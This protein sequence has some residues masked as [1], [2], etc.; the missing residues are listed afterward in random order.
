MFG[1]GTILNT[2][3]V[4]VGSAFGLAMKKGM[5]QQL[6]DILMSACGL[7]VMFIGAS[8]TFAGMLTVQDGAIA[9]QGS[10]LLIASLVLGGLAGQLVDIEKRMD[11]LGEKLKKLFHAEGD[12]RFVD[13]FVSASL[14]I[15]VGAMAIVGSIQDGLNGDYSTLAVKAVLDLI[16]MVVFAASYGPGAMCSAIAIFVYQGAIT[17]AAHFIGNFVSDALVAD[18]S[19]IGS[20]LIFC[21]GVNLA[22]GKK[23]K[24]GNL[25]PALIVPVIWS[26]F[27]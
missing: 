12:S 3:A 10:M 7:A 20:A 26:F 4:V 8:G 11:T 22:F 24:V 13:G 18:L 15:C 21:V 27:A 6:Q 1:I 17:V 19:Y 14:T 5:K 23:F 16:I 2:L 9:T 25:L